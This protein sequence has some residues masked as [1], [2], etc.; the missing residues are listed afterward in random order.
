MSYRDKKV[1]EA[2]PEELLKA[3]IECSG[4]V[5]QGPVK[6]T[7]ANTVRE[8]LVGIG[9]DETASV[10]IHTEGLEELDK[11]VAEG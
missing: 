3:L 8:C 7:Y 2:S 9:D 4:G 1:S 5:E 11:I 10:F 6:V